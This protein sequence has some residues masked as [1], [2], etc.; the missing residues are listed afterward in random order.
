MSGVGEGKT[1]GA[2]GTV[3]V[4][5]GS[6]LVTVVGS[7]VAVGE[8]FGGLRVVKKLVKHL[9]GSFFICWCCCF[10]S[11]NSFCFRCRRR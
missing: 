8:P 4:A 3:V 5:R 9:K 1:P 7:A 6:W 2:E 11:W 10:T